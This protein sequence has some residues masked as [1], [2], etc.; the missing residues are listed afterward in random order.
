MAKKTSKAYFGFGRLLSII[1]V[2]IPITSLIFGIITN[3]ITSK[4]KEQE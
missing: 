4:A 1:F 2:I 3:L